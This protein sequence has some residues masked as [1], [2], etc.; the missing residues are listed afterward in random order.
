MWRVKRSL[1]DFCAAGKYD[2]K[3]YVN[4]N[5]SGFD[6][7]KARQKVF[8]FK[9]GQACTEKITVGIPAALHLFEDLPFWQR[10]FDALSIRTVTSENYSDA[11]KDGKHVA[12]AEF[13][14]PMLA[15][16]GHVQYLFKHCDAVF[17]PFYLEKKAPVRGLRRQ[18]CY[19]TQYSP[20]L[21][22]KQDEDRNEKEFLTPLVH[23]LH[24]ALRTKIELHNTLKSRH[25]IP[26]VS[27]C[28]QGL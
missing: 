26:E 17:L 14:A 22:W 19:Y 24:G 13:C 8:H 10:F 27:G 2:T 11:L 7:L 1:T 16:H 9:P 3:Q 20:S 4:R 15:L 23:Y 18:Y 28:V 12:D 5:L 21:I 25:E 6:L